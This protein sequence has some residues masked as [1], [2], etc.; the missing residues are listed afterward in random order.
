MQTRQQ[1]SMQQLLAARLVVA[2]C[3]RLLLAAGGTLRVVALLRRPRW[4]VEH[5]GY[6]Q[7]RQ[8]QAGRASM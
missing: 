8:G 4:D 2:D 3:C 1:A 7:G 5:A 6:L